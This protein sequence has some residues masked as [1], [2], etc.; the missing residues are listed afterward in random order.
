[1][2]ADSSQI[3][4]YTPAIALGALGVALFAIAFVGHV[5]LLLTYK[6][7]YF[8]LLCVGTLMEIIGYVMRILSSKKD[9]YS[10]PFFVVQYFFIVVAPVTFSAAIYVILSKMIQRVGKEYSPVPPKLILWTFITCDIIAT[11]VQILG[12]GLVGSAYSNQKNPNTF[13]NILLAGLAFQVFDFLIFI[14]LFSWFLSKAWKVMSSSMRQFA[15]ATMFATLAVYL[16]TCFRLAETAQAIIPA[17]LCASY[18]L[19]AVQGLKKALSSHEVYF[20]CLEFAPIVM[21]VYLFLYYHPG[22]WLSKEETTHPPSQM[23]QRS[24]VLTRIG[25]IK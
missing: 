1:M 10:V 14:I 13:N 23:S 15:V 21:A 22:R 18:V 25:A 11:I 12:A 2:G 8:S 3:Y 17:A 16:R 9:P 20:G 4:G 24:G 6:T 5:F 7:W 19:T